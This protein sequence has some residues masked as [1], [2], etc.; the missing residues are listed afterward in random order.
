MGASATHPRRASWLT[1]FVM[2]P[3]ALV[4]GGANAQVNPLW[5]H[6]K[7]YLTPLFQPPTPI[8]VRLTDQFGTYDHQVMFLNQFMNPTVKEVGEPFPG[9]YPINNPDLHYSWWQITQQPFEGVVTATNQF[10]DHT[11]NVHNASWLLNPARKNQPG[12]PPV[13]NHYKC[14]DCDGPSLQIP[15]LLTDQFGPFST[16]VFF[17]RYFC[18][19]VEKQEGLDGTGTTYPIIDP[20]QHYICYVLVPQDPAPH[21]ATMTD[22][23]VTNF[24]IEPSPGIF[25]CVPTLK[26][27][28]TATARDT[29]GRLKLLYR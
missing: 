4:A 26:T 8:P 2:V 9:I 19:P 3:L 23:F 21:T 18:N 5:D 27:G 14:Y 1:L 20:N 25:L 12:G 6:Y 10:G 7:V 17:P 29:W 11:L 22:Q 16:A 13:G 28:V 24:P 15:V